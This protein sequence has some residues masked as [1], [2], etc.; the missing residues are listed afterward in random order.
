MVRVSVALRRIDGR[1]YGAYKELL[2][3]MEEV[4]GVEVRVVRVQGDPY[5]T[6]SVVRLQ[7]KLDGPEWA[8]REPVA[9][10]DWLYRRLWRELASSRSRMGEGWSG[11]MGLPKPGPV[12][13]RRSGLLIE[14][15]VVVARVWAGL[16]S[17]RR[18]V[19][20]D[21][22][23]ELLLERLPRAFKRAID[24]KSDPSSLRRHVDSWIEQEYIRSKLPE[25]GLVSFIG[26]GSVL[27]REHGASQ[28]PLRG[29]KPFKSPPSLRVHFDLP[30]GRRVSGM[31][32]PRGLTVIAGQ[33]F[34]GKTTLLEAIAAGVYNHVP[35]DGRELVVTVREAAYIESEEGRFVSGV[36]ISPF[37]VSAPNMDPQRFT[38]SD[39]SGATSAASSIQEAIE[40]GAK[41]IL[42]DEDTV[43]T[44]VL[45]LDERAL[46]LTGARTV[47]TLAELAPSL[48]DHGASVVV[49]STGSAPLL[50]V[51][52]VVVVMEG[53][54]PRDA[55]AEAKR[56]A[57]PPPPPSSYRPPRP[58]VIVRAPRLLRP[59]VRGWR[60]E[61]RGLRAPVDLS[62]D[63]MLVEE[64][65]L[66]SLALMAK[67]LPRFEGEEVARVAERLAGLTEA[68]RF[69]EL[70][71]GEPPP[72]L[73]EVR[74]L[75]VAYLVNRLP[76]LT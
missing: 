72:S 44:N 25:R 66:A 38:T 14:G 18:R 21:E 17:R 59:R 54:E 68:W 8:L 19:L 46:K 20:A 74:P 65:Q 29:A 35:G 58:R 39:A 48:R 67:V 62:R 69:E 75:D 57:R 12:M 53:F 24:W 36:D 31:G 15:S 50:A 32:V 11:F 61:D 2:K 1:R 56:L 22:A 23:A 55:T 10:A 30:T 28:E 64:G 16:P 70:V 42:L 43:A 13:L 45:Y 37:I 76:G 4:E 9:Y 40:A 3:A 52:D 71:G 63:P 51:A 26:D 34:H 33:A 73:A 47:V 49:A 60:L 6:P 41:L 27:P 5:A 7:A